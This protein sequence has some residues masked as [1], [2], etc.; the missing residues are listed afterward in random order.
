MTDLLQLIVW[1]YVNSSAPWLLGSLMYKRPVG[2]GWDAA[3]TGLLGERGTQ[4]VQEQQAGA[5]QGECPQRHRP[6]DSG[7]RRKQRAGEGGGIVDTERPRLS[8]GGMGDR[9]SG[10]PQEGSCPAEGRWGGE[11]RRGGEGGRGAADARAAG[12]REQWLKRPLE[13]GAECRGVCPGGCAG[14]R[15]D[16]SSQGPPGWCHPTAEGRVGSR[17]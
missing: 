3:G 6:E 7:R 4:A 12:P 15:Q 1:F 13:E 8:A 5:P 16:A 14:R 10:V 17:S 11:G 2:G 9:R